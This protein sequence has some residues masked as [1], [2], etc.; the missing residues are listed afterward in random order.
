[1]PMPDAPNDGW[2]TRRGRAQNDAARKVEQERIA[3]QERGYKP[4]TP[5][6]PSENVASKVSGCYSYPTWFSVQISPGC[7]YRFGLWHGDTGKHLFGDR[8]RQH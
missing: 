6:I 1:M 5:K 4:E 8:S 2:P 3:A 7:A